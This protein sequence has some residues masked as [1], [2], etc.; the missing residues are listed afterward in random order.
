MTHS[1]EF[2]IRPRSPEEEQLGVVLVLFFLLLGMSC[3]FSGFSFIV[4]Q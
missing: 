4:L 1:K 2:T 3:R